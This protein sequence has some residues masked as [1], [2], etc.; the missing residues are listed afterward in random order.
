LSNN[1]SAAISQAE[2]QLRKPDSEDH[3]SE[4]EENEAEKNEKTAGN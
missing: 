1:I 4:I 2:Q 3:K